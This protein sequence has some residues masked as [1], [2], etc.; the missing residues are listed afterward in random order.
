MILSQK[1]TKKE[2]KMWKYMSTVVKNSVVLVTGNTDQRK[3]ENKGH[4][5]NIMRYKNQWEK[6]YSVMGRE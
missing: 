4:I 3:S 1:K 2:E 5:F 6:N